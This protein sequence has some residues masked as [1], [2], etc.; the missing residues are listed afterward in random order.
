LVLYF[1]Y[2]MAVCAK[3]VHSRVNGIEL[4]LIELQENFAKTTWA[5]ALMT[6]A[7]PVIGVS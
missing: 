2:F 1:L 6:G 3:V 5:L 7:N 4:E